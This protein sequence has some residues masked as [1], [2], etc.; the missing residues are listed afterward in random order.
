M[1]VYVKLSSFNT[2]RKSL[3]AMIFWQR[4]TDFL[5]MLYW[6]LEYLSLYI[7]KVSFK[8]SFFLTDLHAIYDANFLKVQ[9]KCFSLV[10]L[11]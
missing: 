2:N 9:E 3:N 11:Q 6:N 10:I 1:E 5:C 4:K 7:I 8:D